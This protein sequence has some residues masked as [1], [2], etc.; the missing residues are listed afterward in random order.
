[1]MMDGG[2]MLF[3]A[4]SIIPFLYFIAVA[5][6]LVLVI[7]ILTKGIHLVELLIAKERGNQDNSNNKDLH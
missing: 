7:R 2:T 6:I 1:M 3:Q 5:F 4:L